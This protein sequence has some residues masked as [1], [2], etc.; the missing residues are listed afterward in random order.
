M[1]IEKQV[2]SLENSKRLKELGVVRE[3]LFFWELNKA[4]K[5]FKGKVTFGDPSL[6]NSW[7]IPF[8]AYTVAEL[9]EMLPEGLIVFSSGSN[10]WEVEFWVQDCEHE[11]VDKSEAD[12]RAL[13][14]IWLLET[15]RITKDE[16]NGN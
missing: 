3:S 6:E 10:G 16:V 2:C 1:E 5:Y 14:L 12:A 8:P 13:M 11:V 4:N 7:A 9:G 15:G